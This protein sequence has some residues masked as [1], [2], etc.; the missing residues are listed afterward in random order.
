[1]FKLRR[2]KKEGK[3]QNVVDRLMALAKKPTTLVRTA[4]LNEIDDGAKVGCSE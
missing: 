2:L 3:L 1:M 4:M